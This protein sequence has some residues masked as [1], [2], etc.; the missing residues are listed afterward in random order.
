MCGKKLEGKDTA[1]EEKRMTNEAITNLLDMRLGHY[2]KYEDGLFVRKVF[3][4]MERQTKDEIIQRISKKV[5]EGN[6][7]GKLTRNRFPAGSVGYLHLS[8]GKT[9]GLFC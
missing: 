1:D 4:Y 7:K 8:I 2:P 9:N 3:L 6:R 5:A